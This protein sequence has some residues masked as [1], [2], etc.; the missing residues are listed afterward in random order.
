MRPG[1]SPLPLPELLPP[2]LQVT[3]PISKEGT[4]DGLP[5]ETPAGTAGDQY[6][7]LTGGVQAVHAQMTVVVRQDVTRT[8]G[9][10]LKELL[11]KTHSQSKENP[12]FYRAQGKSKQINRLNNW[13]EPR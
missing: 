4:G 7:L 3:P 11:D 5:L 6:E 13:L 2:L 8:Y 1:A 10:K 12:L 9:R